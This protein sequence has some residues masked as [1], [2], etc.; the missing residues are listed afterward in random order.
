MLTAVYR[1]RNGIQLI[2]SYTE[3]MNHLPGRW[4]QNQRDPR[5][6]RRFW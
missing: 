4:G 6:V 3:G 1:R 5:L 2:E